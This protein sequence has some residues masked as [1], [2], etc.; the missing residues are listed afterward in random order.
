MDGVIDIE[1]AMDIDGAM[2]AVAADVGAVDG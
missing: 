2:E 1:G